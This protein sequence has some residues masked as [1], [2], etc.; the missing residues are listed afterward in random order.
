MNITTLPPAPQRTDDPDAYIAKAD[1]LM[2]ALPGFVSD[3]NM[4]VSQVNANT[5][6]VAANAVTA[7]N[8]A[9]T[10]SASATAAVQTAN[11]TLWVSGNNYVVG[12]NV[13]S[14]IT[15]MTYRRKV[16]G[17]GT[18]DPSNDATNWAFL[19]GSTTPSATNTQTSAVGITLTS[20][21]PG[22]QTIAM[23]ALG[24]SV[25]L[26]NATT[27]P[28]VGGPVFI[29]H[30]NG[31]YG[32]GVR[33]NTG[34]L[35]TAVAPGGV[36]YVA[37]E[38]RA[39]AAG[40][41]NVYGANLEPGLITLDQTLSTTYAANMFNPYVAFD[42]NTSLHFAALASNGFAAFLVDNVGKLLT[43]P[44]TVS[45][46][47]SHRPVAAF[48]VSATS[49]IVFY[50]GTLGNDSAAVIISLTGASPALSLSVGTPAVS[51]YN[52]MGAAPWGGEDSNGAPK[53]AQ[54]SSTSYLSTV[55]NGPPVAIAISVTGATVSIGGATQITATAGNPNAGNVTY[56]LTATTALVLYS[57]TVGNLS[58]YGVVV[59]VAGT[60]CTIGVPVAFGA[61][62]DSTISLPPYSALLSPTKA[63]IGFAQHSSGTLSL[64][65]LTISGTT[66]TFG[67]TLTTDTNTVYES[68]SASGATRYN[69]HLFALSANSALLWYVNTTINSSRVAVLTESG[70]TLQIGPV[71]TGSF[72]TAASGSSGF[73]TIAN[74]NNSA[75]FLGTVEYGGLGA[76]Q[77]RVVPHKIS[78]T[79][80]TY[81]VGPA[82]PE[83]SPVSEAHATA[84]ARLS[85]GDY[86]MLTPNATAMPVLRSNGDVCY[87]RGAVTVPNLG[88]P[89]V[90]S[91]MMTPASNRLVLCA[92][93][94]GSTA[95]SGQ[96]RILNIEVAA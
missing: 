18:T 14:P 44:I 43:T 51:A 55:S 95:G 86:L 60:V 24:Q 56:A 81:G 39:T 36:A 16:A 79:A 59:S 85:Q 28:S 93:T 37:L 92:S 57:V 74:L 71:V 19:V 11:T 27:M 7:A 65:A 68:Y 75:E 21:S 72:A 73:G 47:S 96:L 17:A 70:G 41:W 30:N 77:K 49:A 29:L 40:A 10:A 6:A 9:S 63:V 4:A 1:A 69:P 33:D 53:I 12:A 54:L 5:A 35:L 83:L 62:A 50:G 90:S 91:L 25:T 94:V 23:T 66:V 61:Q 64:A 89:T 88:G 13:I 38:S 8:A 78:G 48:K 34:T 46:T 82:L 26:P 3:T 67:P 42:A 22:L 84:T 31:S 80:I 15:F 58:V 52:A 76:F 45:T 2:A 87:R 32:F 20:L